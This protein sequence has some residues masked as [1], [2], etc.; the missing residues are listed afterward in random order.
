MSNKLSKLHT[1]QR[2]CIGCRTMK[3]KNLLIRVVCNNGIGVV[4]ATQ[5][6]QSRGVYFCKNP[7]CIKRA[8]KN[9]G[10][11]KQYGFVLDEQLIKQMENTFES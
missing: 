5:K 7:D 3:D 8:T 10:F 2:M 4:D 1:P 6:A 9:K 11:S